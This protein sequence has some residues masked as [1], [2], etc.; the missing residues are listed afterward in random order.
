MLSYLLAAVPLGVA[1]MVITEHFAPDAF[2]IGFGLGL[3]GLWLSGTRP[4][5]SLRRLPGQT[6]AL[7]VYLLML[8]RDIALSGLD[9]ARRVAAR[10]MRLQPGI[11]RVATGDDSPVTAALSAHGI[12]ITPGELVTGIADDNT[13]LYVHC[14]D[15]DASGRVAEANQRTRLALFKRILGRED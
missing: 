2:L 7:V 12:T 8:F 14:L 11:L 4:R 9:V 5:L 13:A 10:D 1:W 15:T 6:A 3:A